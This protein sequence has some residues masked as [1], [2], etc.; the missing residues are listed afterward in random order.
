MSSCSLGHAAGASTRSHR[1]EGR[2]LISSGDRCDG[3]GYRLRAIAR[4]TGGAG[5]SVRIRA[6]VAL[7]P[8]RILRT[9]SAG[10]V[11]VAEVVVPATTPREMDE[12]A[13]IVRRGVRRVAVGEATMVI[14]PPSRTVAAWSHRTRTAIEAPRARRRATTRLE[15]ACRVQDGTRGAGAGNAGDGGGGKRDDTTV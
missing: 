7:L 4:R 5:S 8:A 15:G 11:S 10:T 2:T 1:G 13:R 9:A 14:R 6:S 3:V 12:S